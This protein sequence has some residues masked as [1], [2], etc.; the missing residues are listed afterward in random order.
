MRDLDA[1]GVVQAISRKLAEVGP[2][3]KLPLIYL[4][5]SILK[6][7]GGPYVAEFE[8]EVLAMIPNAFAEVNA[9]VR[10]RIWRVH[11]TWN[12]LFTDVTVTALAKKFK[13][14]EGVSNRARRTWRRIF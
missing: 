9:H 7:V 8:K 3:R 2:E 11:G 4:T 13:A 14:I 1:R 10:S 6:N 5:D 12:G